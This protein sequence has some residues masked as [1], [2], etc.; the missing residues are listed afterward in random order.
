MER[1]DGDYTVYVRGINLT[2]Y[3]QGMNTDNPQE[4]ISLEK[5]SNYAMFYDRRYL[6]VL[7]FI[8]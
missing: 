1:N 6:I 5:D 2:V 7:F 8:S 4:F 3:C